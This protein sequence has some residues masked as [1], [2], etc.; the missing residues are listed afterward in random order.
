MGAGLSQLVADSAVGSSAPAPSALRTDGAPAEL[1]AV[2]E[3]L[4]QTRATL[5]ESR[6]RERAAEQARRELVTFMSHDLRTPLAGLRAL[7]EGLE[8]GVI[9]DVPRALAHLRSTVSRMSVLVDDL[10]ALS[11]VQGASPP[12][13]QRLVSLTELIDDVGSEAGPNAQ[14]HGVRLEVEVPRRRP[15]RRAR[16]R[17]RSRP[18]PHQSGGERHPAHRAG[19]S[20]SGCTA[21]GRLTA[22][23]RSP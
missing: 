19:P 20:R 6:Q 15:A 10:F 11:R 17:R 2:L 7:A 5:A 22:I 21:R 16:Y 3:D 1:A 18:G 9:S 13:P 23:W 8:D 12:K 14:A 4:A